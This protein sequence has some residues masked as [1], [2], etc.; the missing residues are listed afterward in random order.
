MSNEINPQ[1]EVQVLHQVREQMINV[2][3]TVMHISKINHD[4]TGAIADL[5]W[6]YIENIQDKIDGATDRLEVYFRYQV[7][8]QENKKPQT[9][10]QAEQ[11]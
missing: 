1:A 2:H 5:L 9:E 7:D 6:G 8:G 11:S 3:D 10:D 4:E